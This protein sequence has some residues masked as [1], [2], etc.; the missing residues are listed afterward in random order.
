MELTDIR[1]SLTAGLFITLWH[2][3]SSGA[4]VGRHD[5][6]AAVVTADCA[7]NIDR[8]DIDGEDHWL[9]GKGCYRVSG[10]NRTEKAEDVVG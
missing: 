7:W 3:L 9:T 10:I 2:R 4:R 1:Q 5:I 8:N 6:T